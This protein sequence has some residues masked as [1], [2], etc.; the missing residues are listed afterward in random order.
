[1]RPPHQVSHQFR[2]FGLGREKCLLAFPCT[3]VCPSLTARLPS[4][5]LIVVKCNAEDFHENLWRNSTF[6]YNS[7]TR[8]KYVYIFGSCM[9]YFVARVQCKGNPLFHVREKTNNFTFLTV[10]CRSETYCCVLTARKTTRT[11]QFT[12]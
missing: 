4:T 8:P 10:E 6:G 2:R 12:L 5:G 11:R 9:E 7:V 1:M 3:S